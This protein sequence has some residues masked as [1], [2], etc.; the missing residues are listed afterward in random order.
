MKF[1]GHA[2]FGHD[3]KKSGLALIVERAAC[4][5]FSDQIIAYSRRVDSR[6]SSSVSRSSGTM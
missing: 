6:S 4:R 3:E 2:G 1:E 5:I